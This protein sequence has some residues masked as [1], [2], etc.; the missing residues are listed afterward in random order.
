MTKQLLLSAKNLSKTYTSGDQSIDVL[1]N[2]D[3]A[4]HRGESI[5]I[6]GRSGSG[7][8]TLLHTLGRLERATKGDIFF[9]N[10]KITPQNCCAFRKRKIGFIFQSF[11][12][13][14]DFTVIE[15]ILMPARI[16][17]KK[18]HSGSGIYKKA[19]ELLEEIGLSH[20][21]HFLAKH[22]SGGEKQRVAIARALINDPP[23]LLA[24]EPTGN[25]DKDN[26]LHVEEILLNICVQKNKALLVVTHDQAFAKKCAKHLLLE[27]G[28]LLHLEPML[29]P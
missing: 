20:R 28:T 6:C 9:E 19:E 18:T 27:N 2:I 13:L 4:I 14:E 17:R 10:E 21:T 26:A 8:S 23:L 12:L 7:K 25:L 3:F 22:L 16:A 29:S 1:K 5:A 11:N 15:N 24:D